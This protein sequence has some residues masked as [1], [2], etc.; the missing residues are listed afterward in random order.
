VTHLQTE[1]VDHG[2]EA[3]GRIA[4]TEIA[5]DIVLGEAGILNGA[6]GDLGM[7]LGGGFVGCM[8]GGMLVDPGNVGLALDGQLQ[9][10]LAFV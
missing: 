1:V 5:V 9:S 6:F 10:P 2:P 8:P 7:E 3:A 4:R